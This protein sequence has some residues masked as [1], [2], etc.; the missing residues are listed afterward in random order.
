M[1][2]YDK[3]AVKEIIRFTGLG[4]F[5]GIFTGVIYG[6]V[7]LLVHQPLLIGVIFAL[8]IFTALFLNEKV[9]KTLYWN[10]AIL[11]QACGMIVF[12]ILG[13]L[14][15]LILW[16]LALTVVPKLRYVLQKE[17]IISVSSSG[18]VTWVLSALIWHATIT[19][20]G[21][22]SQ[23]SLL[24]CV[25]LFTLVGGVYWGLAKIISS[26][27]KEYHFRHPVSAN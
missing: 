2:T 15:G 9:A 14:I 7:L 8:V 20:P 19:N 25:L 22:L 11:L 17:N 6:L 18:V 27:F 13:A 16:F 4:V 21:M 26:S 10:L 1:F 3:N 5:L 23:A 12:G 24:T